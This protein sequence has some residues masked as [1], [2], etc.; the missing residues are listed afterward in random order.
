[1]IIGSVTAVLAASTP[2]EGCSTLTKQQQHVRDV[3][4][5]EIEAAEVLVRC[6]PKLLLHNIVHISCS[7]SFI[8]S[9][10]PIIFQTVFSTEQN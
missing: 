8:S 4:N 5:V 3:T 6:H 7:L 9:S 1:M 10:N 2:L